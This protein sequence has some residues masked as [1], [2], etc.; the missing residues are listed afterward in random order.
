MRSRLFGLIGWLGAVHFEVDWLCFSSVLVG[1]AL[2]L[3]WLC[4]ALC[5]SS[6]VGC[7]AHQVELAG[8]VLKSGGVLCS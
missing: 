8:A 3:C 4:S 6:L 2:L 5:F 1:I 7:C